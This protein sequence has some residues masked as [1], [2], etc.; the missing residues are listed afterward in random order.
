M[1]TRIDISNYRGFKQYELANLSQVN[2][3]VGKNNS[4]KS[5]LLESVNFLASGGDPSVL[6]GA[7]IRRGEMVSVAR[8]SRPSSDFTHLFYGHEIHAGSSFEIRSDNGLP[9]ITVT[10]ISTEELEG[11]RSLF[12]ADETF[13]PSLALRIDRDGVSSSMSRTLYISD[14]GVYVP[15]P[16]RPSQRFLT[17][18]Q[19]EGPR[20]VFISTDSL[21]PGQMSN[22]WRQ[23]LRDK[24]ED[25]VR[26]AMTILEKDLEDIVFEPGEAAY[27]SNGERAGILVSFK[28]QT[29]RVPL[30]SMGDGMRRLLALSISLIHAKNGFLIIDEIDTG[31]HYSIMAKMWELVIETAKENDIQVFATTHSSDCLRGMGVLC[32]S[33]PELQEKVAVHKIERGIEKDISFSGADLLDAVEQEIEIR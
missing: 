28:N 8:D 19:R 5:A 18:E 20:I 27:R 7:A 32:K 26:Q 1:I 31:F 17:V 4:G 24:H 23:I 33:R 12:E 6:S 16:R 11:D 30:G 21:L 25:N 13:R 15:D 2:L 9:K 3:L 29:G 10:A 14:Q 22:M